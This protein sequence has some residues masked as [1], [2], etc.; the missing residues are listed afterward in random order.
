MRTLNIFAAVLVAV[1]VLLGATIF[2]VDQRQHAMVFQ[3]G[4]IRNVIEEPGLYFKWL[5]I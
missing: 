2:T 1:L 4:E 5:L 3:L